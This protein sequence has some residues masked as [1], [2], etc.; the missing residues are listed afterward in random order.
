VLIPHPRLHVRDRNRAR[1]L[2]LSIDSSRGRWP[3]A[4][5]F[6]GVTESEASLDHILRLVHQK[7]ASGALIEKRP[8]SRVVEMRDGTD[9]E[10]WR[11]VPRPSSSVSVRSSK[12]R[13]GGPPGLAPGTDHPFGQYTARGLRE[14]F[15]EDA[16]FG[17]FETR[18][19]L[20]NVFAARSGAANHFISALTTC[21][22]AN[23]VGH[24]SEAER[25]KRRL[26]STGI[27]RNGHLVSMSGTKIPAEPA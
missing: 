22:H 2:S 16:R 23:S 11:T 18:A 13:R 17:C 27:H 10:P 14:R 25:R 8:H 15:R 1:W 20:R 9:G 19:L 4:S 5:F 12:A 7:I 21:W 6:M 24:R 26:R 3:G